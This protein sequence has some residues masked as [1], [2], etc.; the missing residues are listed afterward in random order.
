VINVSTDALEYAC[1]IDI[2]E[3]LLVILIAPGMIGKTVVYRLQR[4]PLGWSTGPGARIRNEQRSVKKPL[5]SIGKHHAPGQP[6]M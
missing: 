6:T 5:P 2:I 4:S 1:N 3:T